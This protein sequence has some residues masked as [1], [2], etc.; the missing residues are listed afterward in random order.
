MGVLNIIKLVDCAMVMAPIRV[1]IPSAASQ[2]DRRSF[3]L[4]LPRNAI[5][6]VEAMFLNREEVL[7]HLIYRDA[8][9]ILAGTLARLDRDAPSYKKDGCNDF[10]TFY[11]QVKPLLLNRV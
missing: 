1:T 3:T 6:V 11:M 8:V 2:N 10:N 4:N 7:V 9:S 5:V